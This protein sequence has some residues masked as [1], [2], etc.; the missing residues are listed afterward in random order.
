MTTF[1]VLDACIPIS[2]NHY[3]VKLLDEMLDFLKGTGSI[4]LMAPENLQECKGALN[5]KLKACPVL[6]EKR[7]KDQIFQQLMSDCKSNDTEHVQD[8]D[9]KAIALAIQESADYLVSNDWRL[10]LVAKRYKARH[11]IP[12]QS[13]T[14]MN[15]ANLFWF[16]HSMRKDLFDHKTHIG[17]NVKYYHHIEV[18]NTHSGIS[19]R[20]WTERFAKERFNPYAENIFRTMQ[21]MK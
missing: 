3:K 8:N 21:S 5:P 17:I 10:I 14:L 6:K 13:V 15:S 20:S 11:Q 16:M 9:Y 1:F 19:K 7:V 18:P 2:M 4:A 12:K